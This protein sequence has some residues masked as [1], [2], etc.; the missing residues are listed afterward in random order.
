MKNL[1]LFFALAIIFFGCKKDRLKIDVSGIE[2]NLNITRLEKLLFERDTVKFRENLLL[3]ESEHRDFFDIYTAYVLKI[4]TVDSAW[5]Y[6]DLNHFLT[7]TVF[8]RV[9]DSVLFLF[10][11]F[12]ELQKMITNGFRHYKYY[13]PD[14]PVPD[15]YTCITGFNESVFTTG[16]AVGIGLDKYMGDNCIFYS[17]LGIPRYKAQKMY[18]QK[19]VP[20]IFFSLFMAEFPKNEKTD[21]LL[22]EMV[23]QGK[24]LYFVEAMCPSIPDSVL[25]GYTQNQTKWCSQ[26]EEAMWTFLAEH[27]L[28]Y[29][30]DRLIVQKFTGDAPFTVSFSNESPGRAGSWIGWRIIHSFMERNNDVSLKE[31]IENYNAQQI[32]SQSAYFPD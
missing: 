6:Q 9:A 30:S 23:Y 17:Y 29:N 15:V 28:L 24:A 10:N 18:P 31:M 21:N 4:G 11:D 8:S 3:I 12:E 7:D 25:L 16:D 13:F 19:M 2:A 27:K 32:L 20:D 5:F 14:K 1:I 26:N 22:S